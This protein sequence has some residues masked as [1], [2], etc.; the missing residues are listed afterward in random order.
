MNYIICGETNK[1]TI[2]MV[3]DLLKKRREIIIRCFKYIEN[4]EN[5]TLDEY[6]YIFGIKEKM[7]KKKT[8]I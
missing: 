4:K 2:M 8:T 1:H 6:K 5:S 3:S 7:V